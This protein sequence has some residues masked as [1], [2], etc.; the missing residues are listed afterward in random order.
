[1]SSKKI[2]AIGLA[3]FCVSVPA[4]AGSHT[5]RFNEVFSNSSGTVQFIEFKCDAAGENF[6]GGLLVTT[7]NG[8][9]TFPGN[10][11]GSTA[12]KKLL[13]AT[14]DF[15][16][17]PGAPTPDYIIP[18]NFL[19][20][21]GG[22][23]RYNPAGNYDTWVYGAGVIPTDGVS[24]VQFTTFLPGN[25]VDTFTTG[26]NSP[27]NY[28]GG[29]GSVNAACIPDLDGDGYASPGDP[30]CS[31]GPQTDCND[32][33]PAINP[34]ALEQDPSNNCADAIDNDC[35]TFVDCVDTG[36]ATAAPECVPTVSE[37]G[38]LAL[39]LLTLTAG[40]VMLRQRAVAS[41]SSIRL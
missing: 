29:S 31:G 6:T 27:A 22:T 8:T 9:F 10:L 3:S 40:S 17:L 1:M 11:A 20:I 21:N 33:N 37:W 2:L 7:A 28:V 36:C 12:N 25:G 38:V 39:A 41:A 24:S 15:A 5:W 35:D 32:S 23:L 4:W 18:A 13:L 30:S 19:P 26:T 16:A 14:S 34:G